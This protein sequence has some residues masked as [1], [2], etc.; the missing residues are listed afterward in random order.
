MT[1]YA[2]AFEPADFDFHQGDH[3]QFA[4]SASTAIRD[5]DVTRIAFQANIG[6]ANGP[7]EGLDTNPAI[8]LSSDITTGWLHAYMDIAGT[9]FADAN[10]GVIGLCDTAGGQLFSIGRGPDITYLGVQSVWDGNHEITNTFLPSE[11]AVD[12]HFNIAV[13]GFLRVYLNGTLFYEYTG[14]T[15]ASPAARYLVFGDS[16][17]PTYGLWTSE[18]FV[19]DF[20]TIGA[21]VYTMPVS[22][23]GT[24]TQWTGT[25]DLIDE[26]NI[27]DVDFI[28]T[29]TNGNESSFDL[30]VP[31][32]LPS[33]QVIQEVIV[34]YRAQTE[35]SSAVSQIQPYLN[36]GGTQYDIGSA[37]TPGTTA[38]NYEIRLANNPADAAAFELADLTGMELGFRALT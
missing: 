18:A 28:E 31:G 15:S 13:S 21:K 32:S 7:Q 22:A 36:I 37:V 14:D 35:V 20:N 30:S 8:Q 24:E 26:T 27:N 38:S 3:T 16:G 25:Y 5:Q 4:T 12:V 19:A 10:I 9:L 17:D 33:G 6:D 2:V 23:A 34:T 1:I 11:V 29:D